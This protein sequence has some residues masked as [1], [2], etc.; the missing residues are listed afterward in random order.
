M[1]SDKYKNSLLLLN[2]YSKEDGIDRVMNKYNLD[3]IISPT[4]SPAWS[5]DL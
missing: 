5:S 3:A 4:G 1:K 2:K